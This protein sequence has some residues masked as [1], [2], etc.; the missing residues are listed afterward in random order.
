MFKCY[1]DRATPRAGISV[2]A[3]RPFIPCR[4][5]AQTKMTF[6]KDVE[7]ALLETSCPKQTSRL[8]L[9]DWNLVAQ[10]D[11]L[12][13]RGSWVR[14]ADFEDE[15][16]S[17]RRKWAIW[18]SQCCSKTAA[19]REVNPCTFIVTCEFTVL[20]EDSVK[21][22]Y[23]T[24]SGEIFAAEGFTVPPKNPLAASNLLMSAR[25]EAAKQNRLD[26]YHQKIKLVLHNT[27]FVLPAILPLLWPWAEKRFDQEALDSCLADL[28]SRTAE[29]LEI[30]E[31]GA[32]VLKMPDEET[33]PEVDERCPKRLKIS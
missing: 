4:M 22:S 8:P 9:A 30:L 23:R 29:E 1:V 16:R 24:V 5:A 15:S 25:Q 26:S 7:F 12:I 27:A 21:T 6:P 13:L 2:F 28:V 20:H 10:G 31:A 33:R 17:G 3:L 19:I 18:Q 11:K 32:A 14:V